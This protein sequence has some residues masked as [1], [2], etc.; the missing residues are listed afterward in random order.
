MKNK[1]IKKII[2][3]FLICFFIAGLSA[4]AT[5]KPSQHR[6]P[7]SS[8]YEDLPAGS[9][10]LILNNGSNGKLNDDQI[11]IQIVNLP[12]DQVSYVTLANRTIKAGP[13]GTG[14]V[15]NVNIGTANEILPSFTLAD[16]KNHTLYLPG[17]GKYYGTRI[18]ISINHPLVMQ[19][20]ATTNGYSQPNLENLND[21]NYAISFDWFEMT[22]DPT[23]QPN[24]PHLDTVSFGG[25]MTQID[26]FSIPMSFTIKGVSGT[27]AQRG[28]TLGQ[29]SSSGVA[30]RDDLINKYL[31]A[32][33][34]ADPFKKLTQIV[35]GKIIRLISPY[36]SP[37][38]KSGGA[39]ANYFDDYLNTIWN[40]YTLNELDAYDQKGD[41]GNHYIGHVVNN[42][43]TF[44]RNG[45]GPY[46]MSKPTSYDV[47]TCSGAFLPGS[48]NANAFGAQFSA[49]IN[50]NVATDPSLWILS[51]NYYQGEPAND[52]AKFWHEVSIDQLAYGFGFDDV[53]SR[54]SVAIL[55]ANENLSTLTLDI[56]W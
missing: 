30:S 14:S 55:P 39:Y 45:Q 33:N 41:Q 4:T 27:T 10:S 47:F 48:T 22:Y 40:Y 29:G 5:A 38:F 9:F 26:C 53:G 32:S 11:Y 3:A 49:A 17:D 15:G 54:S 1:L 2:A 44:Y 35:G 28:I 7:S 43:L 36:H 50:R 52:W 31:T 46:T 18:Y 34:I 23:P 42:I 51:D 13:Q 16:V 24:N 37:L 8:T 20:N 6:D 21:P 56:G 12:K 19:I 25:N